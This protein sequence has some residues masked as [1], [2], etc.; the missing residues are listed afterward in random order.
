MEEKT[1]SSIEHP[2]INQLVISGTNYIVTAYNQIV[3]ELNQ[4]V[5]L[6][7]SKSF[8]ILKIQGCHR[9]LKIRKKKKKGCVEVSLLGYYHER[10]SI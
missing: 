6:S 10:I 9:E 7:R 3:P 5:V 4:L 8:I 2:D 1:L